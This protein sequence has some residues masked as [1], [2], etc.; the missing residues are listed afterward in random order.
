MR[1]A[2]AWISGTEMPASLGVQGP[3]EI[4]MRFRRQGLDVGQRHGVVA[5]HPHLGAQLAQVLHQVVGEG[6][7][8]VDHEKHE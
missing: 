7:V 2:K 8:V 6:I 4:T 5:L 3:G 1:P